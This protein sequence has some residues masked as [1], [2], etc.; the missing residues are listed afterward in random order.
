MHKMKHAKHKTVQCALI[1]I[2][3]KYCVCTI[4]KL[5]TLCHNEEYDHLHD[6]LH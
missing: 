3:L 2:E 1:Q 6:F 5:N 4:K